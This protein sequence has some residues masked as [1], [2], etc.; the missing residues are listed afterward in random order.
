MPEYWSFVVESQDEVVLAEHYLVI[1]PG[2]DAFNV[3]VENGLA[4]CEKLVSRGVR[5]VRG[6]R[7]DHLEPLPPELQAWPGR[8]FLLLEDPDEPK[9]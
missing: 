4:F 1:S 2:L 3:V 8:P 5:V 9:P 6:Q 7:T